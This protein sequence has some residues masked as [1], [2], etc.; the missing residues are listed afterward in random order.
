V[1]H[2]LVAKHTSAGL[3]SHECVRRSG[4]R[5]FSTLRVENEAPKTAN[6]IR[7]ISIYVEYD[8]ILAQFIK[9]AI[10]E[11]KMMMLFYNALPTRVTNTFEVDVQ[12]SKKIEV[13]TSVDVT[14][15]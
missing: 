12:F 9:Q 3:R 15:D 8:K 14:I 6:N 1:L 4:A 10:K 13:S 5:A 11:S 7:G 2:P